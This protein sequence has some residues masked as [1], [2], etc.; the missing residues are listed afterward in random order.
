[1]VKLILVEPGS[2]LAT[3]LWSSCTTVVASQ[4]I[5]PEGRAALAAARRSGRIG[6][7]AH[8]ACVEKL[9][10]LYEAVGVIALGEPL[11]LLAGEVADVY[12]LRA[13]DAVHLASAMSA[14]DRSLLLVT[15][16]RALSAAGDRAGHEIAP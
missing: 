4:V 10:D 6:V 9:D 2:D 13:L 14:G 11:A 5:Y 8:R 16:N 12:G 3:R 1:M 15:W 7:R